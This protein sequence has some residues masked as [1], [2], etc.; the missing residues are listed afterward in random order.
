MMRP[1]LWEAAVTLTTIQR[2]TSDIPSTLIAVGNLPRFALAVGRAAF[3]ARR[4]ATNLEGMPSDEAGAGDPLSP[5]DIENLPEIFRDLVTAVGVALTCHLDG[6]LT[7]IAV[8]QLT[9]LESILRRITWLMQPVPAGFDG[10]P[11][12]ARRR[13]RLRHV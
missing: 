8:D 7:G 11:R 10:P 2:Q 3:L 1:P 4:L 9:Q 13:Y 5:D 6:E 12:P